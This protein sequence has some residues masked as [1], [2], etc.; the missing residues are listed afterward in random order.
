ML[1]T[2]IKGKE[3]T[4]AMVLVTAD[5]PLRKRDTEDLCDNS[6]LPLKKGNSLDRKPLK[7]SL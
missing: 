7:R 3:A 4:L 6:S 5:S 2:A 1:P